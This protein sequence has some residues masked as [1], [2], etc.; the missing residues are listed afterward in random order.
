MLPHRAQEEGMVPCSLSTGELH[1][2]MSFPWKDR[3]PA[4][5]LVCCKGIEGFGTN[6]LVKLSPSF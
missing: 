2:E 1:V 4:L 3:A 5:S 6:P